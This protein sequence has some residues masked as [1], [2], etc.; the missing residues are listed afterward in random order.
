MVLDL[1]RFCGAGVHLNDR[2][3]AG[4]AYVNPNFTEPAIGIC[5]EDRALLVGR[6]A[7]ARFHDID[8]FLGHTKT[9]VG[10]AGIRLLDLPGGAMPACGSILLH[11]DLAS[12]KLQAIVAGLPRNVRRVLVDCVAFLCRT[13]VRLFADRALDDRQ[14][15]VRIGPEHA[16]IF[17]GLA[18]FL[19]AG[20]F[21]DFAELPAPGPIGELSS[22][23]EIDC[24]VAALRL[25]FH[26]LCRW[27]K[28]AVHVKS[29]HRGGRLPRATTELLRILQFALH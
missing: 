8:C 6:A 5:S 3:V 11:R 2:R 17:T 20:A 13:G 1:L 25:S 24:A 9:V 4:F 23:L 19:F 27:S 28:T 21:S 12:D 22:F 14:I 15:S 10:I 29:K 18:V 7:P 16:F 26:D